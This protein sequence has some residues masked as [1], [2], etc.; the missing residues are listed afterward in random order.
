MTQEI[1]KSLFLFNLTKGEVKIVIVQYLFTSVDRVMVR[2]P[3]DQQHRPPLLA[4]TRT[5]PPAAQHASPQVRKP[6]HPCHRSRRKL[7]D[8][9]VSPQGANPPKHLAHPLILP[10]KP[11]LIR[12]QKA[13]TD[14]PS[15]RD[16]PATFYGPRRNPDKQAASCTLNSNHRWCTFSL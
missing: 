5:L 2:L 13:L 8:G 6:A 7:E 4:Q 1:R 9:P 10:P 14:H 16:N 15:I 11:T 3:P 12:R